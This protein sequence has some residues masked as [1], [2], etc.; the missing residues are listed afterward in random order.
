MQWLQHSWTAG[1]SGRNQA[2]QSAMVCNILCT[3]L[4][5]CWRAAA[6]EKRSR[7]TT[8]LFSMYAQGPCHA[9]GRIIQQFQSRQLGCGAPLATFSLLPWYSALHGPYQPE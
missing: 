2:R 9:G 6:G 1:H 7:L 5:I 4:W 3:V 8:H